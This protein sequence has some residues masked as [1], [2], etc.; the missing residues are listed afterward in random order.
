MVKLLLEDR[1][2][3]P[4]AEENHGSCYHGTSDLSSAF[5]KAAENNHIEIV[6]LLLNHSRFNPCARDNYG[7]R[8]ALILF[9]PKQFNGHLSKVT[10]N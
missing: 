2:V 10:Q 9:I 1:R 4:S 7:C 3:N 6:N 5:C 8:V